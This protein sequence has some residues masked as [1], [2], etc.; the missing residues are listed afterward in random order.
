MSV[1]SALRRYI[2]HTAIQYGLE[3]A[4][5]CAGRLFAGAAERGLVF[6]LHHVRPPRGLAF[7][8]NDLL[9]ITPEFL[10]EAIGAARDFGLTPVALDE[11]PRL[12]ADRADTRRFVSFTLDDGYRDNATYAAPV[13]RKHGVPYTIFVSAGF[14]ERSRT[15]WWKTAEDLLRAV[16]ELR[17]DFGAGMETLPTRSRLQKFAA[18]E[19]L[20]EFVDR[21]DEDEAVARIDAAARACGIDPLAIVQREVM[22]ADALRRL[23]EDPLARLGA[24]SVTHPNLTRVSAARLADELAQSAARV[25]AYVGIRPRALA[26]PY[27]RRMAVGEREIAAARAAGFAMAV[28]TQPG[29]VSGATLDRITAV[30]RVS[31]NGRYQRRRYVTALASGI[32]VLMLQRAGLA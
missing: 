16:D 19:R 9:E 31:L 13:F 10:D 14:V 18:F 17:F 12:L 29:M 15:I 27:G 4:A 11:L 24:H 7:E 1:R 25:E 2:K 20:V 32:P 23:A 26:Y 30:N 6:T 3:L 22:D 8:P 5:L 28:T 21:D